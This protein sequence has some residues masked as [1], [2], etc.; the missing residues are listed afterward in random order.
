MK[1]TNKMQF[2]FSI[3]TFLIHFINKGFQLLNIFLKDILESD[4]FYSKYSSNY[5]DG[6]FFTTYWVKAHHLRCMK[7]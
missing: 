4:N 7:K 5:R 1:K 3:D 6:Q 2:Y